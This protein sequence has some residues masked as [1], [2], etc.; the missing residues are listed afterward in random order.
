MWYV[1]AL[2]DTLDNPKK[3]WRFWWICETLKVASIENSLKKF[4]FRFFRVDSQGND[5][6]FQ[7][8]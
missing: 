6:F 7:P 8:F 5:V 4:K 2:I 3:V 1:M